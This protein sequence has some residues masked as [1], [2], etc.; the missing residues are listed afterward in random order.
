MAV[1]NSDEIFSQ[2]DDNLTIFLLISDVISDVILT[3]LT[4]HLVIPMTIK[5][6]SINF[7]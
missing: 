2:S 3:I 7:R 6:I 4:K 1:H 5:D